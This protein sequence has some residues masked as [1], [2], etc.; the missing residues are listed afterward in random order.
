[1]HHRMLHT[2]YRT[3]RALTCELCPVNDTLCFSVEVLDR[4]DGHCHRPCVRNPGRWS[5]PRV[6]T[7]ASGAGRRVGGAVTVSW[8]AT[9]LI[10]TL[11]YSMQ[12]SEDVCTGPPRRRSADN[13]PQARAPRPLRLASGD[14]RMQAPS[15]RG[16]TEPWHLE[17]SLLWIRA[18]ERRSAV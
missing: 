13:H 3:Q 16:R 14:V 15:V 11:L 1:M 4:S 18:W 8:T 17:R 6:R 9:R 7:P 12:A 5:R 2:V 10:N